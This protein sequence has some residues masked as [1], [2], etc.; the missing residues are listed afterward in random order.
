MH[1]EFEVF[2]TGLM[3]DRRVHELVAAGRLPANLAE[4]QPEV[5]VLILA[6][7]LADEVEARSVEAMRAAGKGGGRGEV[8][9]T[10]RQVA[11]R[12]HLSESWVRRQ[13][14]SIPGVAVLGE[15]K[16]KRL[17]I[18][19]GVLDEFLLRR[20]VKSAQAG[21]SAAVSTGNP[22]AVAAVGSIS[23]RSTSSGVMRAVLAVAGCN[24]ST[25]S[26]ASASLAVGASAPAEA[27][28]LRFDWEGGEAGGRD[29]EG[30]DFGAA[31]E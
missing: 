14:R 10:A 20:Q 1:R 13:F 19:Q 5:V 27:A 28:S 16:R 8:W 4:L 7:A 3:K 30:S 21:P 15:R 24:V 17:K 18:P 31:A 25:A 11:R 12:L 26:T 6:L 9:L 29:S 22:V 23:P 2:V